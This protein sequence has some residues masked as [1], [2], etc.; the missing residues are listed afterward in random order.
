MWSVSCVVKVNRQGGAKGEER[1]RRAL[2]A[3]KRT[4]QRSL[5]SSTTHRVKL[6]NG[7][8]AFPPPPERGDALDGWTIHHRRLAS[9]FRSRSI[10]RYSILSETLR[11][12][13]S[14]LDPSHTQP[15]RS[16]R[17][18]DLVGYTTRVAV[19][20]L[21]RACVVVVARSIT[22]HDKISGCQQATYYARLS[23]LVGR[24]IHTPRNLVL[25]HAPNHVLISTH[26]G[27]GGFIDRQPLA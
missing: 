11:V 9:Q 12:R 10:D 4:Q 22:F 13:A 24:S 14:I 1:W 15:K 3:K 17:R 6:R 8:R 21:G 16:R 2:M 25:I 26:T 18:L 19:G 23:F 27:S 7:P 5:A 20:W